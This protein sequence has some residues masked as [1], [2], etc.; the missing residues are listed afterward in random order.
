M[1]QALHP[2]AFRIVRRGYDCEQV[3][4]RIAALT[5]ERDTA[6][7]DRKIA[8]ASVKSLEQRIQELHLETQSNQDQGDDIV[9][10]YAGLGERIEEILHLAEEEA[11]TIRAAVDQQRQTAEAAALQLRE[12]A[13]SEATRRKSAAKQE[14]DRLIAEATSEAKALRTEALK[15]AQAKR[16]EAGALFEEWRAKASEAAAEFE[17]NLAKRREQSERSIASRE[18]KAERI[19]SV[20]GQRAE[21]MRLE[22][23]KLRT[24]SERRA[25]RTVETSDLYAAEIVAAAKAHAEQIRSEAEREV[26]AIAKRRDHIS[27]QMVNFREMLATVTDDERSTMRATISQ[28]LS[29][30]STAPASEDTSASHVHSEG[31]PGPLP[32]RRGAPVGN[33]PIPTSRRNGRG[34]RVPQDSAHLDTAAVDSPAGLIEAGQRCDGGGG[35]R[36]DDAGSAHPGKV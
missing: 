12:E 2:S 27:N 34:A 8:Q 24:D 21:Q 13:E 25:H 19:L 10:P 23:E 6:V 28:A 17:S 15:E 26:A 32:P 35:G 4:D 31:M 7:A 16:E 33:E 29:F 5:S 36:E 14:C 1:N 11:Q 3:G 9:S 30:S 18:D 20:N 22:A